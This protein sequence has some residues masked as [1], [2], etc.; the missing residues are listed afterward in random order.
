LKAQQLADKKAKA[1][2]DKLKLEN[3]AVIIDTV[4][5]PELKSDEAKQILSD[6]EKL[7]EKVSKFIREKT[8]EL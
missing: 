6:V 3:L 1:A 8:A 4:K 7:L 5:F 2:P